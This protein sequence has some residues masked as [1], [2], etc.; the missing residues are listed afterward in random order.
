MLRTALVS[1]LFLTGCA[2]QVPPTPTD[3]D[4]ATQVSDGVGDAVGN[5]A[6]GVSRGLIEFIPGVRPAINGISKQLQN[7]QNRAQKRAQ[8]KSEDERDSK[9]FEFCS[10]NPCQPACREF[11]VKELGIEPDCTKETAY[12]R[13]TVIPTV[14]IPD[15]PESSIVEN[16]GMRINEYQDSKGLSHI[17]I[18][19]RTYDEPVDLNTADEIV[20]RFQCDLERA[21]QIAQDYAGELAWRNATEKQRLAL[22]EISFA[23]GKSGLDKFKRMREYIQALDWNNA[24]K[25]LQ[26]SRWFESDTERVESLASNLRV[27]ATHPNFRLVR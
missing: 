5:V 24:A 21:E 2:S 13:P 14:R 25:E 20:E 16:E 17:G 19:S 12:V 10:A 18:G 8:A 7:R 15:E 4:P 22:I 1:L 9:L 27:Q 11:I 6:K 3:K 26:N 23:L